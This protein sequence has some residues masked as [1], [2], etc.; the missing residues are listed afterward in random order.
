MIQYIGRRILTAIPVL[1]GV[2]LVTFA[3]ARLIP[4]GPCVAMLGEKARPEV[5]ARFNQE[6]GFDRP[7]PVQLAVYARDVFSGDLGNSIR[8]NRA[9]TQLI[10]ERLPLT[11]E[12]GII[13]LVIATLIGIPAGILSAI[14][15]NSA[16]DVGTMVGANIGVSMPVFW[17]GL[18]LAY[19]FALLLKGTP[20]QLPPSGR[21]SAGINPTPFFTLYGWAAPKGSLR[22]GLLQFAANL[23]IFNALITGQWAVMGDALKHLILPSL[24][25]A[26]IPMSIIARMTRASMLDVLG[27]DYVRTARA[28]GL[29]GVKVIMAHAFKNAL[30]PIATIIGLQLGAVFSG[31]V[32]TET[33]FGLAGV[34]RMLFEA[35]T[36]RD[37][38]VIQ[39]FT[40]VIAFGY[41]AVNLLVD[42]SYVFF[43]P[44]IRL[45]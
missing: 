13:A 32:L 39:G 30:L 21:L 4:G 5:C 10:V 35:I 2:M 12:L 18:M 17:L 6:K 31:A 29:S 22:L 15:R 42:L 7:I 14:R 8:F 16:I 44:R 20:L 43:D 1:L 19:L 27:R 11:I 40:L 33:I 3:M 26:T 25:L 34:G 45:E 37:Y 41:V 23:Y 9:V 38:P 28:K 36:A 24:A